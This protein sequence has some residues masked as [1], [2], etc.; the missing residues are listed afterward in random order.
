MK[1]FSLEEFMSG[2]AALTR[3]GHTAT[4][5]HYNPDAL[6]EHRVVGYVNG[7]VLSWRENGNYFQSENNSHNDLTHMAPDVEQ[8]VLACHHLITNSARLDCASKIETGAVIFCHNDITSPAVQAAA[9][10]F[11]EAR[12]G[13]L[14]IDESV[15]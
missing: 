14:T 7:E 3:A 9:R 4:F 15:S 12:G 13:V 10:A 11:V 6:L 2:K 1:P 5:V 8:W